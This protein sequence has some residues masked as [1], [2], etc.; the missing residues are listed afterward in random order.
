MT[1]YWHDNR[2]SVGKGCLITIGVIVLI[3]VIASIILF[4]VPQRIG[5]VQSPTERHLSSTPDREDAEALMTELQQLGVNTQGINMYVIPKKNSDKSILYA[6]FDSSEGFNLQALGG[7]RSPIED[8]LGL[9]AE[10]DKSGEYGIER[11]AMN[12]KDENGDS[13]AIVTAPTEAIRGFVNGTITRQ[14]FM[15]ALE[16]KVELSKLVEEVM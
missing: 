11:I 7:S 12:Y 13:L 10:L 3:L 9:L 15:Q 2:G 8:A 4:N 6:E 16:G 14:Q 5:I 1:S